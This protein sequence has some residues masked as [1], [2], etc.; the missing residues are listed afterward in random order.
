M[1][2]GRLRPSPEASCSLLT[3]PERT[4]V[5]DSSVVRAG[6]VPLAPAVPGTGRS[7]SLAVAAAVGIPI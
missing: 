1:G 6:A 4:V 5:S 3:M 7:R 2:Q